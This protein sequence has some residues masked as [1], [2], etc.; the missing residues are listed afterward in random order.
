MAY[1]D[2][3]QCRWTQ[4]CA[5]HVPPSYGSNTSLRKMANSSN[6]PELYC[7]VLQNAGGTYHSPGS[8]A[9]TTEQ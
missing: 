5:S 7:N 8:G 6:I 2:L 4:E 9:H 3:S 1:I